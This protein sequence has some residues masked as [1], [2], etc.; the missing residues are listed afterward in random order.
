[1]CLVRP[2]QINHN[3]GPSPFIFRGTL[4]DYP[5]RIAQHQFQVARIFAAK[6]MKLEWEYKKEEWSYYNLLLGNCSKYKDQQCQNPESSLSPRASHL[7]LKWKIGK[8]FWE[9][10]RGSGTETTWRA[11]YFGELIILQIMWTPST[12]LYS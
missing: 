3:F 4:H 10:V 2:D 11:D 7:F 5:V 6:N 8:T 9:R 1:V 12:A